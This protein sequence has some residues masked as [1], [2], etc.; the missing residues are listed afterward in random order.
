MLAFSIL[1]VLAVTSF[2]AAIRMLGRNWGKL[3]K[4]V[5]VAA[6]AGVVHFIWGQKAD[7][8]EPIKWAGWLGVL[9]GIRM[10]FWN[11]KRQKTQP[12]RGLRTVP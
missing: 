5:Y 4:L 10:Y 1:C 12:V 6:V 3:H 7:Y 9:L 2:N 8:E 11:K